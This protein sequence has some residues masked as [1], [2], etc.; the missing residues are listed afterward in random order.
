MKEEKMVIDLSKSEMER[1]KSPSELLQRDAFSR[2]TRLI[3]HQ[4]DSIPTES[5]A[6]FKETALSYP[7]PHNAVLI[8]G[9][10]GSG[11]TTFLL[12][13]LQRLNNS[14]DEVAGQIAC[15]LHV[16]PM[17][18]PTLIETKENIIIV[19]LS[20]IEAATAHAP[21]NH[22]QLDKAKQALAEGL[23]LLD[24]IGSSSVYG[25]EWEDANW[26]MSRGL[27]KAMKG[28]LF[29]RKLGTYIEAALS[30]LKKKAFVLAFDDVDTNFS[31]GHT[32][33]ETIRKYLTSPR[34]ILL[35][36]GDLDLYG[37]LL[38]RS[39]YDTFGDKILKH[40]SSTIGSDKQNFANAVLELEEQY[41]L[42]VAPP[43]SRISMLPLG[44]IIQSRQD[45]IQLV[46]SSSTEAHDLKRWA[47]KRIREQLLEDS[48]KRHHA[49]FDFVSME[50][51]RLVIGYIRAL[52][53]EDK[54]LRRKAVLTVF[55]ARLRTMGVPTDLIDKG[56]YDYTLRETFNWLIRQK[57]APDLLR[58]GV[59]A[60]R[61]K[62][63]VIHCLSLALSQGM[64][65]HQGG[66]LQA[67]FALALPITMMRRPLLSDE[68]DREAIFG[69]LWT[70]SSPSLPE[71]A[72]RIGS[73]D[74]HKQKVGKMRAS[75]FGSVG[76]TNQF[77]REHILDRIYGVKKSGRLKIEELKKDTGNATLSWITKISEAN[78]GNLQARS[79]V[80]WFSIDELQNE[81]CGKFSEV[82][83]LVIYKR[84][85]ERGE[86]FR[87][88]SALSL[89]AVIGQLLASE[90][91]GELSEYAVNSYV[92]A[93]GSEK[94][95]DEFDLPGDEES[96]VSNGD[97]SEDGEVATAS[98]Q[99]DD[100]FNSFN[101]NL[102]DWHSFSRK[103]VGTDSVSPSMLGGIAARI[104]DDL[105]GLDENVTLRWRSGEILHR[106]I[107]NILHGVLVLTTSLPGR[108][109]SPKDTDRPFAEA[110]RQT[111]F[112]KPPHS[113]AVILLSCP[114]VWAFLN[115]GEEAKLSSTS[116]INLKNATAEALQNWKNKITE[117]NDTE[118]APSPNFEH[119]LTA[120]EIE[121]NFGPSRADAK[122][123]VKVDGFYDVLNV[124]PRYVSK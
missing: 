27:N 73:I 91:I 87:S 53:V 123:H 97:E 29:E 62:A 106:Q 83:N 122:R 107:T 75:S 118:P 65:A 119:W 18:D 37:R 38:R 15:D 51:L 79:G 95:S 23:G 34:L 81:R 5:F 85:S 41:L 24:G 80:A 105:M 50:H 67:L 115:P 28:R 98:E 32:I 54:Q 16:L 20:M 57:D 101:A 82:L 13:A 59:P 61:T 45:D 77:Q 21:G 109:V 99:G 96:E 35:L 43:H 110:L 68:K 2:L 113:L 8:E 84:F 44:G 121:I 25:S 78:G 33:L 76:L 93:F 86:A 108:K 7:R 1:L 26:I 6:D 90:E 116:T 72:A 64:E 94:D 52:A 88:I 4:L 12:A 11:K 19:I 46:L 48:N 42:K 117:K 55:E 111:T 102:K 104:H 30:L 10:R 74:R 112:G 63:I 71:L 36:S 92:P 9:G 89:F 22:E 120:P 60:E 103:Y 66:A 56:N 14:D 3:H 31:H 70:Q 17:I 47:S 114:L 58:F 100:A 124:V 39:I 69:F 49:F 40:D